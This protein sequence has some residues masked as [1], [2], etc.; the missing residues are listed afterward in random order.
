[1]T[2]IANRVRWPVALM[3]LLLAVTGCW[4][5]QDGPPAGPSE[6][7]SIAP[8]PSATDCLDSEGGREA[9]APRD[10]SGFDLFSG[11]SRSGVAHSFTPTATV[12]EVLQNGL[13][14][15]GASPVHIAILGT[16]DA[17]SVR[18]DWRGIARTAAQREEAIRFW[19]GLDKD[20]DIPDSSFLEALFTVTLETIEPM[21]LA[22]AKANFMAIV[23]GGLSEEYLFLTCHADYAASEYL[24]GAGPISPNKLSVAY[25]R[26]GEAR[27]YELYREEHGN[28]SFGDEPLMKEGEYLSTLDAIVADAELSLREMIGGRE[29]VVFLAP[30][31]AH[32]AIAVEVWQVVD[33]WDL[34]TAEDGTVNAVRYGAL[35][36]DPEQTQTL[37]NLKSRVTTA[38]MPSPTPEAMPTRIPN[39]DGLTQYYQD[40]GAYG[41]I[42]PND[43][44][45]MTFTP[46]QEP[47]QCG[48]ALPGQA[49]NSGLMHDCMELLAGK[50]TLRG[51]VILGWSVDTTITGWNGVTTSGT[52]SRVTELDLSS[53]RLTGSIPAELGNLREQTK[54]DLSSNSLT[55]EVPRELG[56]LSNLEAMYLN[57]NNLTGPIPNEIGDLAQLETLDL[58]QNNL[59]GNIPSSI[60]AL[61]Q[62]ETLDLAQ[63]N[64]TGNIPSSIGALAQLETLDL[65]QNNLTGNIPSEFGSLAQLETL[66][67]AQ[68]NLTGNIPSEI[69]ALA[70]LETLDLAQNNLTG[71]IPTDSG[72][73]PNLLTLRIDFAENSVYPVV[74]K[75]GGTEWSLDSADAALFSIDSGGLLTFNVAPNFENPADGDVD[76]T[77]E[78]CIGPSSSSTCSWLSGDLEVTVTVTDA[79]DAPVATDDTLTVGMNASATTFDII[80]NDTDEDG[81]TL[82]MVSIGTGDNAPSNGTA[83][84]K[85]GGTTEITYRPKGNFRG[86]DSFTY[87]VSDGNGGIDIGTVAVSVIRLNEA[88]RFTEGASITRAVPESAGMGTSVG[89]PV[90]ARDEDNDRLEYWLLGPDAAF[91]EV[92]RETGQLTTKTLLD[93]EAQ[94]EYLVWLRVRDDKGEIDGANLTIAV[95]DMDEPPLQP[96]APEV[97]SAGLTSLAVSWKAPDTQGPEITDYDVQYREAGGEFR[98]AGYDGV[99]LST[100]LEDLR[101]G[102]GYEVQVRAI[103]AEG[104]G[105]WSES[106]L[107]ET[108]EEPSTPAPTAT[109]TPEATA[110]PTREATTTPTPEPT[111]TPTSTAPTPTPTVDPLPSEDGDDREGGFPWWVLFLV[112]VGVVAGAA[113]I[114]VA[115]R[116][117]R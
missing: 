58:A 53:E 74:R 15:A 80:A 104:A 43:G 11:S 38:T 102:T 44:Q 29:S 112:V 99:G 13:R 96:G 24:L 84:I 71:P 40:V 48:L 28:G 88:P 54:L 75:S 78:V 103:N 60:G 10:V 56:W 116:S 114:V 73:L 6:G 109:S 69:G 76:N 5:G 77:Y 68:N 62:L 45:T 95:M 63:N 39:A 19:L 101:P 35:E 83:A 65:A 2:S 50:D 17:N 42:T 9:C 72:D 30:M 51:A 25:D 113:L 49:S 90:T 117:R 85:P 57:G 47:P 66:D 86:S 105:A 93:Y 92:D 82:T 18:C 8:S 36:G 31:G 4:N 3:A 21:F 89:V 55:G 33:Q 91:F 79:N 27:S 1:M 16:A 64:L 52:P 22:T 70:Q 26:M 34:Q 110:T 97:V 12:E 41:D 115:L 107:G 106:G 14:Q 32:N 87:E 7:D 59:T 94:S 20:D 46:A 81:D 61:A 37:A 67:L 98:D 100:T 108:E 23:E 111:P